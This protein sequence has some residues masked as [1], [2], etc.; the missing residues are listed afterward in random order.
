[1]FFGLCLIIAIF[2]APVEGGY[3]ES[4]REEYIKYLQQFETQIGGY[5][6]DGFHSGG[7]SATNVNTEK[8]KTIVSKC[9]SQLKDDKIRCMLGAYSPL[10]ITELVQLG[11]DVFD[12][13][14][15]YLATQSNQAL[16]FN[17]DL[18]ETV[19][20][21]SSLCIELSNPV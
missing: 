3:D 1:M 18:K 21:T 10:L 6:L 8:V 7:D 19:S 4:A 5:F 13:T 11:V 15:A 17:F 2:S 20:T 12:S 14:F 16:V 9:I